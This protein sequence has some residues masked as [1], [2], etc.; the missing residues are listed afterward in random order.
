LNVISQARVL[1]RIVVVDPH[2]GDYV[3]LAH[4]AAFDGME[5]EF[6]LDGRSLLRDDNKQRPELCVINI[7]LSDMS[8]LDLYEMLTQQWPGMPVYVVGDDYRPE[9]EVRA[10]TSGATFYFCKP[11]EREWLTAA[12]TVSACS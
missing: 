7:N 9:D 3:S 5:F 8:G 12:R 10:R 4:G 11:L 6:H 1:A 2:P